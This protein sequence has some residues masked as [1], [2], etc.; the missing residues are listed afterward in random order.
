[1]TNYKLNMTPSFLVDFWN[2]LIIALFPDNGRKFQQY[3]V[4]KVAYSLPTYKALSGL[5]CIL[6]LYVVTCD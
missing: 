6:E 4:L 3:K 5:I 1:M 2:I